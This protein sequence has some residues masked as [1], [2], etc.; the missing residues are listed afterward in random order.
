MNLKI[1]SDNLTA[2]DNLGY[3]YQLN[4]KTGQIIWAK[5]YGI[6]LDQILRLVTVIYFW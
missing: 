2:V 4:I 5:N 1:I 3:A 6:P